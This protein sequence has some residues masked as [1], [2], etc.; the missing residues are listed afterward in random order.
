MLGNF[1][2][3]TKQY[4]IKILF[5]YNDGV[6]SEIAIH[7][8]LRHKNVV[9]LHASYLDKENLHIVMDICESDIQKYLESGDRINSFY[10]GIS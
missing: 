9:K 3:S 8:L 5:Q 6:L 2:R 10:S 1:G 7:K 4:A